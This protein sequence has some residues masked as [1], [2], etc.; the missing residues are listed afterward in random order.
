MKNVILGLLSLLLFAHDAY[1]FTWTLKKRFGEFVGT[2]HTRQYAG[3]VL[4]NTASAPYTGNTEVTYTFTNLDST[5]YHR[6]Y[7]CLTETGSVKATSFKENTWRPERL[8]IGD[9]INFPQELR[10]GDFGPMATITRTVRIE[11]VAHAPQ[12]ATFN[13]IDSLLNT[14]KC[15]R[16][17]RVHIEYVC[18][19]ADNQGAIILDDEYL[20]PGTSGSGIPF[21]SNPLQCNVFVFYEQNGSPKSGAW[22]IIQNPNLATDSTRKVVMGPIFKYSP[23][24]GNGYV[25]LSVPRSYLFHDSTKGLYDIELK[26]N[27]KVVKQWSDQ[28]VPNADTLRLRVTN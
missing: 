16:D 20:P 26:V 22:L 4:V 8:E 12:T 9:T 25:S 24:D 28:W 21:P 15:P 7:F 2:I 6:V 3:H 18:E 27:G 11:N 13:N 14:V 23:T 10:F 5:K 1:A 17:K 19:L